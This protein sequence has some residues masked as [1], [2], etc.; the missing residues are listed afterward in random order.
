MC[1]EYTHGATEKKICL[2]LTQA[3]FTV[4]RVKI[5]V[6]Q[7]A[8]QV[9]VYLQLSRNL[10]VPAYDSQIKRKSKFLW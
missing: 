6:I 8:L 1:S 9:E 5:A 7:T 10:K 4:N 3:L 2:A